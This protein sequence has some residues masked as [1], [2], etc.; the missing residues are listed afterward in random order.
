MSAD[1]PRRLLVV[2]L[3]L[4]IVMA[5]GAPLVAITQP[6]VPALQGG[7]ILFLLTGLPI[8]KRGKWFFSNFVPGAM[9]L[10]GRGN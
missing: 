7:L 6:F 5:V 2:T 9:V 10:T 4:L 3:Q 8:L 1:A